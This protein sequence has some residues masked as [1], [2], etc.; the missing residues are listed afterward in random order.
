LLDKVFDDGKPT[1]SI[2]DSIDKKKKDNVTEKG[3]K[4]K[5]RIFEL[6]K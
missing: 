1:F 3:K 2:V 4:Q 6:K 5:K